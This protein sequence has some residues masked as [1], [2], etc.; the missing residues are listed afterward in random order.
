[1]RNLKTADLF[2]LSRIIK[3]MSIKE[4]LRNLAQDV[5]GF[6][7]EEKDKVNKT[8]QLDL[9]MLFIENLGSA[10]QEIY[11]LLGDLES[12]KPK[13]IEAMDLDVFMELMK[14]LLAQESLGKLFTMALK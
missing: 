13:E 4:D 3:K 10:E 12:K 8:L 1:M 14:N 9:L 5:T 2:S 7:K 11:K 6:T